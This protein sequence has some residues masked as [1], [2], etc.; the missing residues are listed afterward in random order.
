MWK[1]RSD[2]EVSNFTSLAYIGSNDRLKRVLAK[3][4]SGEPW[5]L[6][7]IGG[8]GESS[9]EL[10]NPVSGGHGIP[11]GNEPPTDPHYQPQNMHRVIFDHLQAK[12]PGQGSVLKENGRD[13]GK[14][15]FVNGAQGGMG[16]LTYRLR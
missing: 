8:S 2:I 12:F 10:A 9:L 14:N 7:V 6:G 4:R 5:T 13:Q 1:K 16:K 3:M 15:T 11:W